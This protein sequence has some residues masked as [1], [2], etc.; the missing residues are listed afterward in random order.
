MLCQHVLE[1]IGCS[2]LTDDNISGRT[3]YKAKFLKKMHANFIDTKCMTM[4]AELHHG[5]NIHR[6]CEN[7]VW[8]GRYKISQL[9]QD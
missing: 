1:N 9:Q 3:P 8:T 6:S 4:C 5:I 2:E 7:L